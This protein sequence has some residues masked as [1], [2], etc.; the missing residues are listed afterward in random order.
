MRLGMCLCM[1]AQPLLCLAIH[2][3]QA[4][5]IPRPQQVTGLGMRLA[6]HYARLWLLPQFIN[7][8]AL[9]GKEGEHLGMRLGTADIQ[10]A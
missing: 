6:M 10:V 9:P 2:L 1:H 3:V 5:L 4:S 8:Q 7:P